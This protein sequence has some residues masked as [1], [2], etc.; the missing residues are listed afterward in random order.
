MNRAAG[1][2]AQY[3]VV[4]VEPGFRVGDGDDPVRSVDRPEHAA[5]NRPTSRRVHLAR[6]SCNRVA[7]NA[8]NGRTPADDGSRVRGVPGGNAVFAP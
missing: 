5:R 6:F 4:G 1:S 2:L 3:S 8:V 7:G